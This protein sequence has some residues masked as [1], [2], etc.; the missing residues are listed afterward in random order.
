M[1]E[2]RA[3][4]V[5]DG[6]SHVLALRGMPD[7]RAGAV[8]RLSSGVVACNFRI[9]RRRRRFVTCEL[10]VAN[11]TPDPVAAV[12][13]PGGR[14]EPGEIAPSGALRI[15]PFSSIAVTMD[16]PTR[17]SQ[18]MIAALDAH[19]A[20][21]E[22]EAEPL[23]QGGPAPW[24][25]KLALAGVSALAL[26]AMT[27]VREHPHV[28]ALVSPVTVTAG[29]P[30][31]VT[32]SFE[33]A[34][35][36]RYELARASDGGVVASGPL[37]PA[38]GSLPLRVPAA[39]AERGYDLRI[40][41]E[42][43]YGSD[44][45][46]AHLVA[47][48]T[49]VEAPKVRPAPKPAPSAAPLEIAKLSL[50]NAAVAGG[51]PIDVTYATKATVGSVRLIDQ[52]GTVRAEALLSADGHS[53]LIA[54]YVHD[55]Q[56]LRVV[57]NAQRGTQRA[58]ATTGLR[59]LDAPPLGA[60]TGTRNWSD[61]GPIS[62]STAASPN[63]AVPVLI[64]RH[65]HDLRIALVADDGKEIDAVDVAPEDSRVSLWMPPKTAGRT[66]TVVVSFVHGTSAETRIVPLTVGNAPA[67]NAG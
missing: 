40:V 60:K 39:K 44:A 3:L 28:G 50:A 7:E 11:G 43:A 51:Q 24:L 17:G 6:T 59:V 56:D 26:G 53:I 29:R 58:E 4:Q 65:E 32:Y 8:L 49:P 41:A 23:S 19:D 13:Y 20:H 45:R 34:K 55:A 30:F 47:L 10:L 42:S 36:A 62:V 52:V 12:A 27:L 5:A 48:A 21:L 66:F 54:P 22:L 35:A 64:L 38:G 16:F 31:D 46:A 9:I 37:A 61:A 33:R 15:A 57:V 67:P 25:G 2:T 14:L 1:V 18:R 63:S